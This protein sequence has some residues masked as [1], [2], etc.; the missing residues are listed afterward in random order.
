MEFRTNH[1]E[2]PLVQL[3][4]RNGY[5]LSLLRRWESNACNVQAVYWRERSDIACIGSEL[6]DDEVADAVRKVSSFCG[7]EGCWLHGVHH[8]CVDK[9]RLHIEV[10]PET[11]A[12]VIKTLQSNLLDAWAAI[13]MIRD[14]VETLGPV[15]CMTSEEHVACAVAPTPEAEAEAIIAG[16]QRIADKSEPD[17]DTAGLEP[18]GDA[19]LAYRLGEALQKIEALREALSAVIE[20]T[21]WS[22][23]L[24]AM[25][26]YK[27]ASAALKETEK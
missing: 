1:N 9:D 16:I 12:D 7:D 13:R 5:T 2:Q 24:G 4:F 17:T 6:S 14:A 19:E 11:R 22:P 18:A 3:T 25:T 27:T 26:A 10:T 8:T 21:K 23:D 20:I 15:G